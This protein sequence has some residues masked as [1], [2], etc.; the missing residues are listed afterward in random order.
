MKQTPHTH[1]HKKKKLFFRFF[2][3][4]SN[5]SIES[6][7]NRLSAITNKYVC[8]KTTTRRKKLYSIKS[9]I[10]WKEKKTSH[11]KYKK[12]SGNNSCSI[13]IVFGQREN[14]S[15]LVLFRCAFFRFQKRF[16]ETKKFDTICVLVTC[17][18]GVYCVRSFLAREYHRILSKIKSIKYEQKQKIA[19][20]RVNLWTY[21]ESFAKI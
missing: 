14:S 21:F 13:S 3:I 6:L 18:C 17:L 10:E 12:L 4:A 16:W 7:Q 19:G 20:K 15:V 5:H 1:R 8:R 9:F 11:I 2:P